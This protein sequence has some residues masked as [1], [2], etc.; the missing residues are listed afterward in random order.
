MK[1]LGCASPIGLIV[2]YLTAVLFVLKLL[3]KQ[4]LKTSSKKLAF[5]R[6]AF[7]ADITPKSVIIKTSLIF[8]FS[9]LA[10]CRK[11]KK[12]TPSPPDC[13]Y[14]T[15]SRSSDIQQHCRDCSVFDLHVLHPASACLLLCR[16]SNTISHSSQELFLEL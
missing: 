1:C 2:F 7:R 13:R 6:C 15:L 3:Y 10:L 4:V 14:S 5:V 11:E 12:K 9:F 8:F 16:D